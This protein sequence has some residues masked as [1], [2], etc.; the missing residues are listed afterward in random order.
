MWV[1]D[2]LHGGKII[3]YIYI[4]IYIYILFLQN[5]P[6]PHYIYIMCC[7][8]TCLS[9]HASDQIGIMVGDKG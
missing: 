4:Y 5:V 8:F 3:I 9:I 2:Y 6:F 7:F 1:G